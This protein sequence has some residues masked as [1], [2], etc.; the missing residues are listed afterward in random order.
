VDFEANWYAGGSTRLYGG[1]S[2]VDVRL[3]TPTT[4][5]ATHLPDVPDYV[6]QFGVETR[7]PRLGGL[8]GQ[9]T[10]VGDYSFYG[11]RDL[12]TTGTL[13][14]EKYTRAT[15]R[16]IYSARQGYR[17]WAGG[18]AYPTSR[19]GES[20]FLF[21]SKVGIRANPRL[22]LEGGASYSFD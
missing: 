21:G 1:L 13:R 7:I 8:P 18:V 16:L 12:N 4:P 19:Y 14:S 15:A 11:P 20:A 17:L 6:H 2:F 10:F 5:G 3:T 9:F 22:T